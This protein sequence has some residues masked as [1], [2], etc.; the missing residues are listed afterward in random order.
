MMHLTRALFEEYIFIN[1]HVSS[2]V[3]RAGAIVEAYRPD[4]I[5]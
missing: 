2:G 3:N 5:F 1:R 4:R